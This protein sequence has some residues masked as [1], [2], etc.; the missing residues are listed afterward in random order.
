M[1]RPHRSPWLGRALVP[2]STALARYTS[3]AANGAALDGP[4]AHH[5]ACQGDQQDGHQ[6]SKR[7]SHHTASMAEVP[8]SDHP[9]GVNP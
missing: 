3:S 4:R 1:W 6:D 8:G 2:A 5:A 7:S 9:Y